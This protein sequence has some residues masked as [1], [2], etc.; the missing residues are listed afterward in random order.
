[1][2]DVFDALTS[3]RVYRPAFTVEQAVEE[4]SSLRGTQFDPAIL[5]AL[6]NSLDEVLEVKGLYGA[7]M[8][9]ELSLAPAAEATG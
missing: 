6:L 9:I 4:M 5:D 3:D 1:V 7:R 2:A 8:P